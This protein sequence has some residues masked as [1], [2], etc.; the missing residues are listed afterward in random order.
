MIT[1]ENNEHKAKREVYSD[2]DNEQVAVHLNEN[3]KETDLNT[4]PKNAEVITEEQL[5]GVVQSI[6]AAK[7]ESFSGP[8]PHPD[9]MVKYEQ[10]FPGAANRIFTMAEKEQDHRISFEDRRLNGILSQAKRGQWMGLSLSMFFGFLAII[11]AYLG[12]VVL[13]S[14]IAGGVIVAL[15]VVFVLNKEPKQN[16]NTHTQTETLNE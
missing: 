2:T 11:A 1:P 13:A 6:L 14:I 8:L 10:A 4:L 15:A 3:I 16:S 7:A 9:L 5:Q 12:Q